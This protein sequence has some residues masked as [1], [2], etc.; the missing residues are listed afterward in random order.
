MNDAEQPDSGGKV[1]AQESNWLK[2]VEQKKR[3]E[4]SA[5]LNWINRRIRIPFSLSAE[6]DRFFLG[7]IPADRPNQQILDVGCGSGRT[8]LAERG[9]VTGV[10]LSSSLLEEAKK[11]Y[12]RVFLHDILDM[13]SLFPEMFDVVASSDVIGHIP[14]ADKNRLYDQIARV[15]KVGGI[16]VH[17]IECHHDTFWTNLTRRRWPELFEKYFIQYPGHIGMETVPA[18]KDQFVS[19]GFKIIEIRKVPGLIQE[20]GI[21]SST[22]SQPGFRPV[23]PL[24]MRSLVAVDKFLAK[25]IFVREICNIV[26]RP[27]GWLE[28]VLTPVTKATAVMVA[29][30]RVK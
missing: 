13:A 11:I 3:I 24:W 26:L 1:F 14:F 6:R 20:I 21:L 7:Y 18:I 12:A 27:L 23:L 25:N 4:S 22:F 9:V 5:V 17:F 30:R 16:S 28:R 19:H 2:A 29:A 15:T 10:D 8:Y